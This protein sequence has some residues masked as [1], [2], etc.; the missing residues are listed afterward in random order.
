ML[1]FAK[2]KDREVQTFMTKLVN[3]NCAELQALAEGPR[4]E[5]RVRLSVV[6]LV[7]PMVDGKPDVEATFAAVTKEFSSSGVS[8]LVEEP[9]SVDEVI[10]AFRSEDAMKFLRGKAKHLN[11]MGAGYYQ[12]GVQLS[13]MVRVGDFPELE[14][15]YI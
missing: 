8:L 5:G 13:E 6:V 1:L 15:V 10:L 4:L 9:R 3:N 11:P 2:R 12:L 7:V 14:S